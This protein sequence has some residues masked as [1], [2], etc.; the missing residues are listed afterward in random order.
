MTVDLYHEIDEAVQK[1]L[2][3]DSPNKESCNVLLF[4]TTLTPELVDF[5]SNDYNFELVL[6]LVNNLKE[7]LYISSIKDSHQRFKTLIQILFT[8]LILN[9]LTSDSKHLWDKIRFTY[10]KYGK[11]SIENMSAFTFNS[12]SSN[13]IISIIVQ[14]SNSDSPIGIDL[15]HAKQNGIS[16]SNFIE[17]FR[18]IFGSNELKLL[19]SIE[20]SDSKY[21]TF[22]HIWTLKEAFTK[23]LGCG[24]NIDLSEFDYD[25]RSSLLE[26]I[27]TRDILHYSSSKM[28]NEYLLNYNTD[29]IINV[30]KLK[31]NQNAF[32]LSLD[33]FHN[34][35][36]YSS[37]LQPRR[38]HDLPV[39]ITF[40]N[41]IPI[42]KIRSFEFNML[43]ILKTCV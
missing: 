8:R 29:I 34:F 38:E 9:Y 18:P 23:L 4:T 40:I 28:V 5:L 31:S 26:D 3:Q 24:L 35:F 13:S 43:N 20:D 42:D 14:F 30:S 32:L 15:S 39:I 17:E 25:I 41:Q 1:R 36:I 2:Y 37:I 33:N 11:P 10:N 22:N 27:H 21:F 16:P 6:R 7:Q 12:S 19:Q